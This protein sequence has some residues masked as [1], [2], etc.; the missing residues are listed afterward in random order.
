MK[1]KSGSLQSVKNVA[2]DKNGQNFFANAA[3]RSSHDHG[4]KFEQNFWGTQ[5]N[6]KKTEQPETQKTPKTHQRST[7]VLLEEWKR[8]KNDDDDVSCNDVLI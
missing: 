8:H 1:K 2:D 4:K 6:G 5:L 3:I 7:F